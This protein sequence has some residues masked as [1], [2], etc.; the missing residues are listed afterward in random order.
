[1]KKIFLTCFGKSNLLIKGGTMKKK[2]VI[3]FLILHFTL[4]LF[5]QFAGGEGTG[6]YPY[7]ITTPQHLA[8]IMLQ[9]EEGT[10]LYLNCYF[11][12]SGDIDL[13]D[14]EWSDGEGWKP[15]GTAEHPFTGNYF[16][17]WGKI[18][19]LTINRPLEDNV[20]LFG[21]VQEACL[22]NINLENANIIGRDNV[23][24]IVGTLLASSVNLKGIGPSWP[25][26]Y[27]CTVSGTIHG[28]QY[29]GGIAGYAKYS[30]ATNCYSFCD[31]SGSDYIGG[32]YG[33][34]EIGIY[35]EPVNFSGDTWI[36]VPGS[37]Y[38]SYSTG[39]ISG[40]GDMI[41]GFIGKNSQASISQCYSTSDVTTEG[42][43]IGG[44]AGLNTDGGE[45]EDCYSFDSTIIGS[46]DTAGLV[47]FNLASTISNCYTKTT[48]L[49]AGSN[50]QGLVGSDTGTITNSYWD[51]DISGIAE[52][53]NAEGRTTA[54][55]TFPYSVDTFVEWD[56]EN[57]WVEDE[58]M[59]DGS[60]KD[61]YPYLKWEHRVFLHDFAGGSGTEEDPYLIATAYQLYNVRDELDKYFLQIRDIDLN[62]YPYNEGE[63]WLPIGDDVD[64]FEGSYDGGGFTISNIVIDRPGWGNENIGLLV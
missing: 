18:Q 50:V 27:K 15:I 62:Q 44:F 48:V 49:G 30:Q 23:G 32:V 41:G 20:G 51:M 25:G 52:P 17:Y 22:F 45:I 35:D 12:Q 9:D 43:Y 59:G 14:A 39:E 36:S 24:G 7:Y 16:A 1:M 53:G 38:R 11:Q 46:D 21:Y 28:N 61:G 2:L 60:Y 34:N 55:M 3:L 56:F 8:N 54:D 64:A 10:Y 5:A 58:D 47:G 4:F 33:L 63:G 31:V 6:F 26:G 13:S 19:N 37:I 57:I 40:S 29:V 42:T